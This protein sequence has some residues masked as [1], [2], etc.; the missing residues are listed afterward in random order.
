MGAHGPPPRLSEIFVGFAK[1]SLSGFGGVL[2]WSRRMLVDEKRWLSPTE[3]NELYALCQVL[4]GP[5]VINLSVMFG[6]R[7]HGVR[8]AVTA[9][10]GLITPALALVLV[11]GALYGRYGELPRLRGLLA[12]LAAAAAGLIIATSARMAGPLLRTPVKPAHIIAVGAFATIGVLHLSLP[13]VLAALIPLSVGL[14]FW[15]RL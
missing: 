12:A 13:A 4:P 9:C 3:F 15:E 5:N 14:A 8:G 1:I 2:A 11:L 7:V 10:L 6:A